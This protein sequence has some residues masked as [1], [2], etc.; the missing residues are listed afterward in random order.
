MSNYYPRFVQ[1]I[2]YIDDNLE[3]E[4]SVERLSQLVHLSKYHFHRQ[5]SALFGM[6][7]A[8]YIRLCRDK[9]AGFKLAY[10][11]EYSVIDIAFSCGF[12]S[13]E[14]FS[15]AFKKTIGQSPSAFRKSPDWKAWHQ[16]HQ[17]LTELRINNMKKLDIDYQTNIVYIDEIK[18]ATLVHTGAPELIG[19]SIQQFIIWRKANKL[20]PGISR[21]FNLIY[22]DPNT[23]A[24]EDYRFDL[25]ASTN[26]VVEDNEQG[27]FNSVIPS[28]KCA[29]IRHIGSDDGLGE[30]ANYLYGQWLEQSDET[31]RD[32]PLFFERV[33][34]FPEVSENQMITDVYLP[35]N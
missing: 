20:P 27:V 15:R 14:A 4:L 6:T 8:R 7:L 26:Q 21:T 12:D 16:Y 29:V 13:S 24:P 28:G 11:S 22:D 30:I 25:C 1:V 33:S 18:I 9:Q 35:I 31:L 3:Q 17:P 34:F 23:T 10:R 5:F 32:F 2:N 19:Q